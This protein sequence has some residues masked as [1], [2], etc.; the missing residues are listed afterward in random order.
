MLN[1]YLKIYCN[2]YFCFFKRL[3]LNFT[4]I[5]INATKTI[6]YRTIFYAYMPARFAL[7]GGLKPPKYDKLNLNLKKSLENYYVLIYYVIN[8]IR[9]GWRLR[10]IIP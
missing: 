2:K 7:V 5:F 3:M 8:F 4:E 9:Q 6:Q 1:L 10:R